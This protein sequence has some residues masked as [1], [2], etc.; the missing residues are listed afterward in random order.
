MEMLKLTKCIN[1]YIY[2]IY[3]SICTYVYMWMHA[4]TYTYI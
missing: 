4:Y 1:I 3:K 2:S